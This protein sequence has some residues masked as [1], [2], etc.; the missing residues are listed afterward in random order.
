MACDSP[1]VLQRKLP[2]PH[3]VPVPCGKCPSCRKDNISMWQDRISFESLTCPRTST[4]LTLTFDDKYMVTPSV[5]KCEVQKFNKRLHYYLSQYRDMNNSA[6]KVRYF[7]SSEYGD[8]TFRKHYHACITNL[9]CFD[10]KDFN[11]L[12]ESWKHPITKE[13][14][15]I[16]TADGLLPARI[17][18]TVSYI[19]YE[20]PKL[21][22]MYASL[23]LAPLFHLMSKGIGKDWMLE[24]K[25]YLKEN[26][27]YY[28][29]GVFRPLPRYYQ[30]A[31]GL[32]KKNEYLENLNSIWE[33]YNLRLSS[34]GYSPIDPL[35]IKS[36]SRQGLLDYVSL[37]DK[38]TN[39]QMLISDEG[40]SLRLAGSS[41]LRA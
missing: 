41:V 18:Y 31:L 10:K 11:C 29:N 9:D 5:R 37:F 33:K 39:L 17:R 34:R 3:L 14:F 2:F 16:I 30:I 15:G 21:D 7:F 20:N 38:R 32:S 27:G 35:N 24:H 19:S 26:L 4:F 40:K 6:D 22:K 8:Q 23:G 13:P 28:V 12:Y 25:E 36:V 1:Y